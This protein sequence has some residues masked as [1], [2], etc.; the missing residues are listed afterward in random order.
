MCIFHD[1]EV[2]ATKKNVYGEIIYVTK[3]C[4]KCNKIVDEIFEYKERMRKIAETI[5]DRHFRAKEIY[6]SETGREDHF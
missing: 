3:V 4:L 1:W 5:T 2:L 6:K